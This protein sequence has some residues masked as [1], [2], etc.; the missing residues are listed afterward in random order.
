MGINGVKSFVYKGEKKRECQDVVTVEQVENGIIMCLSD[1]VT[2]KKYA[3]M[4]A[5][6][7]HREIIKYY[8]NDKLTDLTIGKIKVTV[9]DIIIR[10]LNYMQKIMMCQREEFAST[11]LVV[12][13]AKNSDEYWTVHIGD[14]IIGVVESREITT[15]SPAENGILGRGTYTTITKN[16]GCCLRVM[17][18]S[19]KG[20][21]FMMTDGITDELNKH[22]E[23]YISYIENADWNGLENKLVQLHHNDDV[24]FCAVRV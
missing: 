1:G 10:T 4:A 16:L 12:I 11:L 7:I 24:G 21:L 15:I 20:D 5:G 8:K 2:A 14:G 3:N 23:E 6:L 22:K 9:G 17:R 13:V 18:H 19:L